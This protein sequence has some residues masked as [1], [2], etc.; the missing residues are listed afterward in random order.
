[1]VM[2]PEM[3]LNFFVFL[4]SVGLFKVV[5]TDDEVKI[6]IKLS[7]YSSTPGPTTA[8]ARVTSLTSPS[9]T[10]IPTDSSNSNTS[11]NPQKDVAVT[12]SAPPNI[13]GYKIGFSVGSSPQPSED[14]TGDSFIIST[15]QLKPWTTYNV[16]VT[17]I[18]NGSIYCKLRGLTGDTFE[19]RGMSK[20]LLL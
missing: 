9:N 8:T 1:M 16:N 4:H 10:T 17:A 6:E 2:V 12:T 18:M 14:F 20:L 5:H 15:D 3:K 19:T 11:I 7:D 13:D